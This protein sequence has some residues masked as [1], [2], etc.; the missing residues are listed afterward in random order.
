[1]IV[2]QT[3]ITVGNYEYI[4]AFQF[5]QAGA[6]NYEVRATGILSTS[7]IDI[8]DSV[9]YGQV[10]APGVMAPYHQ[11]LFS[12]RIDPAIDGYK[13]SLAVEESHPMPIDDPKIH[14]SFGVGYTTTQT[15]CDTEVPLDL[16]ISKNRVFKILNESILNPINNLPVSY[17]LVPHPSQM[18]L[19]H[20]DSQHARRSEFGAHA[21]WVTRYADDE[22]FA[23]GKHTMQSAG[24]EGISAWI[25][26]RKDKDKERGVRNEDI[27]LWHTFGTTHNPRVEDWPVMPCEKMT[28]TLKPV[29]FFGRN[30]GIDVKGSRQEDNRSVL[31]EDSC[32]GTEKGQ[33]LEKSHL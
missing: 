25:E 3:I 6:I 23:A 32:C 2:L 20:S 1:M 18:L 10:V 19:A 9:P 7:P 17:Q 8:G 30:P 4:F 13:N 26:G 16:D 5:N 22:L 29:N 24:G 28:V 11:H 12:L 27:V 14:N 21:L 31:V 15:F 33:V